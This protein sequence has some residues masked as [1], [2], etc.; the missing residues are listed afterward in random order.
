MDNKLETLLSVILVLDHTNAST[1][2]KYLKQLQ[3]YLNYYS[4]YEIIILDQYTN[5]EINVLE[6]KS[7]LNSV[8]SIRWIKTS[9][10]IEENMLPNI[11][12][13]AAIGD[14]VIFLRPAIDP[15]DLV[16]N[17]I[18]NINS[19]YDIIIGV[20]DYPKT[21][22]YKLLR[23]ISN[24]ILYS[25]DYHLPQNA[26]PVCCLSRKAVNT[27]MCSGQSRHE[28]FS[29][30]S[31]LGYAMNSYEYDLLQPNDLK[32]KTVFLGIKEFFNITTSNP[33]K[34][35]RRINI[36]GILGCLCTFFIITYIILINIIKNKVIEGWTT[37]IFFFSIL[38]MI[39]FI[40]LAF[41]SEYIE[42]LFKEI[43]NKNKFYISSE[44]KSNFMIETNRFNVSHESEIK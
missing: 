13:G 25:I 27:I 40:I 16:K 20:T 1:L 14:Y 42:V 37:T 11:G 26:S 2:E 22:C 18:L 21:F 43:Y 9:F 8:S 24:K 32:K 17:M 38:F 29:Q 15:P 31:M 10:S 28:F 44:E 39:L 34:L 36:F 30:L 41:L 12:V 6:R 7:I 19:N 5:M 3:N 33:A 4:D 23:K 35:L